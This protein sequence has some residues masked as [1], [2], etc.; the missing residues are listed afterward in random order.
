ML[1]RFFFFWHESFL[2]NG[3]NFVGT[4]RRKIFEKKNFEISL[5]EVRTENFACN[6]VTGIGENE[7]RKKRQAGNDKKNAID[8]Q[9]IGVLILGG[10]LEFSK[11]NITFLCVIIKQSIIVFRRHA[12]N[13]CV[14]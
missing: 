3:F 6:V 12:Y 9:S 5:V 13:T 1:F 2:A 14:R 4:C 8:E 11:H 10:A 7:R